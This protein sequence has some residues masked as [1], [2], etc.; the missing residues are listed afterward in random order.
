VPGLRPTRSQ[1]TDSGFRSL[2]APPQP[3]K[4]RPPPDHRRMLPANSLNS[5]QASRAHLSL[6]EF[7]LPHHRSQSPRSVSPNLAEARHNRSIRFRP[8]PPQHPATLLTMIGSPQ[9]IA[10]F[11][12]SPHGSLCVGMTKLPRAHKPC[13]VFPLRESR[14]TNRPRT[15]AFRLLRQFRSRDSIAGKYQPHPGSQAAL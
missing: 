1:P 11:T 5:L 9:A 6:P 4:S 12:T 2:I 8:D 10:S 13:Q 3:R 15:Y 7:R 14:K